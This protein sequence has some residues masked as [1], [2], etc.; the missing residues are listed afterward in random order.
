MLGSQ[1]G[2]RFFVEVD[3]LPRTPSFEG[4]PV[5]LRFDHRV[6][7]GD[8]R[9]PAGQRIL[10]LSSKLRALSG[11]TGLLLRER[12]R[13]MLEPSQEVI[14]ESRRDERF[15]VRSHVFRDAF[16]CVE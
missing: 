1:L 13:R 2:T 8:D 11:W 16:G 12:T 7:V 15:G 10:E 9:P 6:D 3:A 5:H 14:W 4:I